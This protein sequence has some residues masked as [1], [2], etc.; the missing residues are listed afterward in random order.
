MLVVELWLRIATDS[1]VVIMRFDHREVV[2]G[3][4]VDHCHAPLHTFDLENTVVKRLGLLLVN[5]HLYLLHR[6]D[7]VSLGFHLVDLQLLSLIKAF[8]AQRSTH[9]VL[10]HNALAG[11]LQADFLLITL[12]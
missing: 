12:V 8:F 10:V 1:F 4:L 3:R 7:G 9:I 11:H 6:V 5:L 2:L